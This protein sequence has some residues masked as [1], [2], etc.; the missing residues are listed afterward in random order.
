MSIKTTSFH[1]RCTSAELLLPESVLRFSFCRNRQRKWLLRYFDTRPFPS[2]GFGY[3]CLRLQIQ[4]CWCWVS[5]ITQIP[6]H[7]ECHHGVASEDNL[8][9][10]TTLCDTTQK[11]PLASYGW[12]AGTTYVWFDPSQSW[13]KH[14]S[15]LLHPPWSL[16]VHADSTHHPFF[17]RAYYPWT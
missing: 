5:N 17:P 15:W 8:S 7:V 16:S 1:L 12:I 10:S 2:A 6:F 9:H 4:I 13:N 11:L 14:Q 3:S